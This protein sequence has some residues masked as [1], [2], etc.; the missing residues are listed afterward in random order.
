MSDERNAKDTEGGEVRVAYCSA[1]DREVRL[2]VP[3]DAPAEEAST[4]GTGGSYAEAHHLKGICLDVGEDCT[5]AF[6]PF[7]DQPLAEGD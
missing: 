5:G 2:Q 4:E 3:P 6:C 1:C 7:G